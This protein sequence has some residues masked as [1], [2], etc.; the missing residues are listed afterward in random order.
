VNL[1]YEPKQE[2][3]NKKTMVRLLPRASVQ[4]SQ[5]LQMPAHLSNTKVQSK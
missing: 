2:F 4:A 3:G 5:I 1:I